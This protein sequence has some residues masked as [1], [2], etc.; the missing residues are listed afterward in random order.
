[1]NDQDPT[2]VL[3]VQYANP[4]AYPPI[5][6]VALMLA[7]AGCRVHLLGISLLTDVRFAEHPGVTVK[8][9]P[10]PASGWRLKLG[11][12]RFVFW[13]CREGLGRRP[14]WIYAS[15]ALATPAA[16]LA[17]RLTGARC[18]YHEHDAPPPNPRGLTARLVALAR[19]RFARAADVRIA[20]GVGRAELLQTTTG[21][22]DVQ[23]VWNTP[24]TEEVGPPRPTSSGGTRLLYHGSIVPARVPETLL[25]ALADLPA[26]V[27][28]CVTGYDPSG[29]SYVERL[30]RI[31][32]ELGLGARVEFRGV[33][34]RRDALMR[35]CAAFDVG[36]S[37]LPLQSDSVNERTMLGASN[38]V[39]DYLACGLAVI[40]P[41]QPDWRATFVSPGYALACD[42][43]SVD[44]LRS[45]IGRLHADPAGRR[46]MGER[47]RQ[48]VLAEWNHEQAFRPVLERLTGRRDGAWK[49]C[50]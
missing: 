25:R 11:F 33:V 1:M 46:E 42:P 39:F 15:D 16:W 27:T 3:F 23:V 5:E 40:V 29:G 43:A 37:L 9:M 8:L 35:Q 21:C 30:Q 38:K 10:A 4:A 32:T 36:L 48:R 50:A 7:R 45:V 18:V 2:S 26:D 44:S 12:L 24:S 28:L 49:A 13:T 34:S 31:S 41:D 47:G 22:S 6:H 20:P 19:R 17:S 14:S